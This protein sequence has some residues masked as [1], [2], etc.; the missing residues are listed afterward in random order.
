MLDSSSSQSCRLSRKFLNGSLSTFGLD[1]FLSG[2]L[3][4]SSLIFFWGDGV[5]LFL[6]GVCSDLVG[7]LIFSFCCTGISKSSPW[8]QREIPD[9]GLQCRRKTKKKFL[10][11]SVNN[12]SLE[13]KNI[14]IQYV[15]KH[16]CKGC[17]RKTC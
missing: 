17:G 11:F 6:T 14:F 3:C 15:Y 12:Y 5:P 8:N 9:L 1:F 16:C 4:L 2:D 7:D 10:I 13:L